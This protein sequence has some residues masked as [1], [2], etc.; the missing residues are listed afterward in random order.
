MQS[1][2]TLISGTTI[3]WFQPWPNDALESVAEKQL[4]VNS[5]H[6]S[7]IAIGDILASCFEMATKAAVRSKEKRADLLLNAKEL[8]AGL[9]CTA[10]FYCVKQEENETATGAWKTDI[11]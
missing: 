3:D 10:H 6:L 4:H 2:S 8:S 7:A 5:N 1:V 9:P 11:T